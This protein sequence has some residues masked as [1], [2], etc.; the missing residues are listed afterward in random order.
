MAKSRVG[1]DRLTEAQFMILNAVYNAND[2]GIDYHN[3]G[4]AIGQ[5]VPYSALG[6]LLKKGLV[7]GSK[8]YGPLQDMTFNITEIGKAYFP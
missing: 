3:I 1:T 2:E 8:P 5:R 4:D 6:I 7:R